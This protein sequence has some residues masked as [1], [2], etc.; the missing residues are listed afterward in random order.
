MSKTWDG[1]KKIGE[2]C[3]KGE[4]LLCEKKIILLYEKQEQCQ[5]Y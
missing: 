1:H 4:K 2:E 3:L 5:H